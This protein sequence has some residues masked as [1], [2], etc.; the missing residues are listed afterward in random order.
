MQEEPKQLV[1]NIIMSNNKEYKGLS[2]RL[3]QNPA[4]HIRWN[5][6]K[7][8]TIFGKKSILDL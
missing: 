8:L 6:F 4:K 7:S 5:V 3:I 1:W 2:R